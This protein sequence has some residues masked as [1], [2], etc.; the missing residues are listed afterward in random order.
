MFIKL[1]SLFRLDIELWVS[2]PKLWGSSNFN[3]WVL[4]SNNRWTDLCK[5]ISFNGIW[6][7][8]FFAVITL[9][10]FAGTAF[11]H[12]SDANLGVCFLE[13]VFCFYDGIFNVEVSL[14]NFCLRFD[15][16]CSNLTWL[17][18]LRNFTNFLYSPLFYFNLTI[19]FSL[20]TVISSWTISVLFYFLIYFRL[21]LFY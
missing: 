20:S 18:S 6:Y 4:W 17:I 5:L 15:Y 10:F 14:A 21:F 11:F 12:K 2:E 16:F 9:I 3:N 13:S 8:A 1:V 19:V 7:G